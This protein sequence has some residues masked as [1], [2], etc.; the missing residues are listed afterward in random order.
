MSE[1]FSDYGIEIPYGRKSGNVKCHCPK[2]KDKRTD[3]RDKSLSVNL[4]KGMWHCHYC[5]WSGGLKKD[6]SPYM[7]Y[8]P[9]TSYRRPKQKPLTQLSRKLVKWFS[10]VRHISEATLLKARIGE[11]MEFMPQV[12][13]EQNTVQF[14]Y[15]LDGELVNVKY[16]TGNK[17]FKLE[18]G[19]ELIPYN[20]DA[21]ADTPECIITEGEIDCLSFIEA[22][23]DDVIS[24]PNGA[25]SNLAYLDEFIDGWL[26][27]KEVIYI[28]SDTDNKG[29]VLRDEL[30]RRLGSERCRIVTYGEDCK[31]ANELLVRYGKEALLRCIDNAKEIPVEGV[32]SLPDYADSLDLLYMRGL[33]PGYTIGH[34]EFD[35]AISFET[36]RLCIV[37]GVP[38]SGKSEFIDEICVRL[39]L[40]HDFRVAYFSPENMPLEYHASKLIEKLVG[41]KLRANTMTKAE[42]DSAKQYV[43]RNFFHILPPNGY[44][45][46]NILDKAHYLVRKR[47][48]RVLVI[49]PY[50]RLENQQ[51]NRSETQY[52]SDVL[53]KL[54]NFAQQYNVLVILMAHP[55]KILK[56]TTVDGV[57]TLYDINGSANF[58]NKADFGIIVHRVK[59]E[60][61]GHV[62]VRIQKV[63][64]KH[65]GTG[66]DVH[67]SYDL[68]NGRYA[69]YNIDTGMAVY[70]NRNFI[71]AKEAGSISQMTIPEYSISDFKEN[72][73]FLSERTDCPF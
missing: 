23:R 68:T 22:G 12:G 35:K 11:G 25:N 60:N 15:W 5:E 2:C 6:K 52:I 21:I 32:Y 65:L 57:P 41:K 72:T 46:E 4:D 73:D 49:D 64:F 66:G 45:V 43:G 39:N 30:I 19:A 17:L 29:I 69:P 44:T 7:P 53:D 54:T 40:R 28:A 10:E 56:D 67:F 8:I 36:K 51:G 24:V 31:D 9:K 33:M 26:D 70:D 14:N 47:G 3:K 34:E 42:Y 58:F 59:G 13:K 61:G 1:R 27:D 55:R 50:N 48:I 37:T 16:R 63:K 62:L 38:S 18:Q 20:I 71:A